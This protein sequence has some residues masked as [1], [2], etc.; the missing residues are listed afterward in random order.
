[1]G[2]REACRS[3]ACHGC[4][5]RVDLAD[6]EQ[7]LLMGCEIGS[8]DLIERARGMLRALQDDGATCGE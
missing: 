4:D 6:V 5:L 3:P 8:W 7:V 1:M 2:G